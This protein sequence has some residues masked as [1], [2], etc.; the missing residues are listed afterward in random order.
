MLYNNKIVLLKNMDVNKLFVKP[1]DEQ[2]REKL[3]NLYD[4]SVNKHLTVVNREKLRQHICKEKKVKL[5]EKNVYNQICDDVIENVEKDVFLSMFLYV[6]NVVSKFKQTIMLKLKKVS[7]NDKEYIAKV[8]WN[9]ITQLKFV[10]S[11]NELTAVSCIK[12]EFNSNFYNNNFSYK[13]CNETITYVGAK[14]KY[15][16]FIQN[17]LKETIDI[18]LYRF[19]SRGKN[20]LYNEFYKIFI[21][22]YNF[23]MLNEK[24]C[25]NDIKFDNIMAHNGNYYLIDF[26]LTTKL[27]GKVLHG[28]N[29]YRSERS[30][31]TQLNDCESLIYTLY[32]LEHGS[33][34][35][36]NDDER[37]HVI[38]SKAK[39][40][41]KEI[42]S[43]TL[44]GKLFKIIEDD[45]ENPDMQK[46]Y[47]D[48]F[49]VF[50]NI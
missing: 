19:A 20:L 27:S 14:Y 35:W 25:H 2:I 3:T 34:T 22:L 17:Q 46:I 48:I 16:I 38:A 39:L 40:R 44:F 42:A 26:G 18:T 9:D 50:K 12:K 32:E 8:L 36:N 15:T 41:K 10:S 45:V 7:N 33:L 5:S 11:Q 13:D 47:N 43:N 4:D 1:T 29:L 31:F 21:M 37:S 23:H 24:F 30:H 28:T 49:N 6:E